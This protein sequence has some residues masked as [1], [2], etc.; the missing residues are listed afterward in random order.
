MD[1]I[2]ANLPFEVKG[3]ILSFVGD[4]VFRKGRMNEVFIRRVSR[5][6][7]EEINDLFIKTPCINTI[8]WKREKEKMWQSYVDFSKVGKIWKL[9]RQNYDY[10]IEKDNYIRILTSE[11]K[12]YYD[13]EYYFSYY[14]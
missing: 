6:R 11:I 10:Q 3:Y 12:Y 7:I 2:F 13:I 8:I 9:I 1:F 4:Y 5:E 14:K